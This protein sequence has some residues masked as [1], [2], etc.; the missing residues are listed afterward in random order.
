M[1]Y[2]LDREYLFNIPQVVAIRGNRRIS[3][4][5]A[6]EKEVLLIDIV[7]RVLDDHEYFDE[8]G[9][10]VFDCLVDAELVSFVGNIEDEKGE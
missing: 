2:I 5:S 4:M 9:A 6:I 10:D 8:I 1:K 7:Q 3:D